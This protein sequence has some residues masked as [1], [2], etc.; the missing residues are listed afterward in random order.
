MYSSME[1]L[2]NITGNYASPYTMVKLRNNI[3]LL[4]N[5]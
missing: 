3:K 5:L 2:D 1:I 4:S